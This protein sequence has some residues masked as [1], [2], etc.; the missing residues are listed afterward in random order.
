MI[1]LCVSGRFEA[2]TASGELRNL[3]CKAGDAPD[4]F[5]LESTLRETETRVKTLF[6]QIVGGE[7]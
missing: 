6:D 4:Y 1:R 3:L 7:V 2:S 5:R